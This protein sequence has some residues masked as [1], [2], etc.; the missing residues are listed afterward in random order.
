MENKPTDSKPN[1]KPGENKKP[2]NIWVTLI[3]TV[4][5]ILLI[6][7]IYNAV[8][9]SQYTE[10]S[11]SD[12]L[13]AMENGQ[14]S[15]VELHYDRVYYLT[16]AEA[17]KPA[18]QQKPCF[19]GLPAGNV[20]ALAEQLNANGVEVSQVI[21]EDNS[22][23]VMILMYVVMFALIFGVMRMLMKRMSGDG[24]MGGFG[25]SKAKV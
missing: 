19:T 2:R 9:K 14:L 24:M 13:S 11:Y 23:I 7:W 18:G 15:E 22:T 25:K 1:E 6:S 21:V 20:M 12:F 4:T 3:I 8:V 5:I 17:A 16:K 10:T